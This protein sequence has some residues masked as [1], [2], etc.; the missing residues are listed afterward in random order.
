MQA[1]HGRYDHRGRHRYS[2]RL[3]AR[4]HGR[5][6]RVPVGRVRDRMVHWLAA[7]EPPRTERTKVTTEQ[8]WAPL[9]S[10]AVA[11]RIVNAGLPGL[12]LASGGLLGWWRRR[13]KTV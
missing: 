12:I 3:C 6:H 13:W 4:Q 11:A 1:S 10:P 5:D 8:P 7:P 2:S 9:A